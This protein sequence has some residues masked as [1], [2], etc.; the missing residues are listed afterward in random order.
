MTWESIHLLIIGGGIC[1]CRDVHVEIRKETILIF[2][3]AEAKSLL[4]LGTTLQYYRLAVLW[5]SI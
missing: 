4:F 1:K 2:Y 5:T 3:F